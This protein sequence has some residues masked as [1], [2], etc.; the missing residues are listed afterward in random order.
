MKTDPWRDRSGK[1]KCESC[2]Y[3][4]QKA[5]T[6]EQVEDERVVGR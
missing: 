1:M 4:V 6:Q 5:A 2:M 3:Y